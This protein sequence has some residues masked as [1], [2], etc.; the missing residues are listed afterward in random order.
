MAVTLLDVNVLIALIWPEHVF[1]PQAFSWFER[2]A[3]HGWAT[4][5]ITQMGFV[6]VLSNTPSTNA[7]DISEA[8]RLLDLNL[9]HPNH[10]FWP[11]EIGLSPAIGLVGAKLQGHR[12]I[13][14]AYLLG[15]AMHRKGK[16]ATFDRSI[17]ALLPEGKRKSDWI[18]ELST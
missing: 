3:R 8:L 5:P 4:C 18:L 9:S 13:T 10:E 11:D 17:A 12:Q 7:P 16:L 15:L 14:D 2:N 6:R 1:H